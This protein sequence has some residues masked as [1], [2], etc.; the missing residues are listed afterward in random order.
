MIVTVFRALEKRT[1][2]P[3]EIILAIALVRRLVADAISRTII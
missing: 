1:I 3:S 2:F